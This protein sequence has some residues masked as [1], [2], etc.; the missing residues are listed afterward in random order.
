MEVN[1]FHEKWSPVRIEVQR[2]SQ[3]P[4]HL[5]KYIQ[6]IYVL[7]GSIEIEVI[8]GKYLISEGDIH[9]I[10]IEDIHGMRSYGNEAVILVLSIN[11]KYYKNT[12]PD[13]DKRIF[14]SYGSKIFRRDEARQ[15]FKNL[16]NRALLQYHKKVENE[17][18]EKIGKDIIEL[19]YGQFQY[20]N[21]NFETKKIETARATII[22]NETRERLNRIISDIYQNYNQKISIE[23][24]A[25]EEHMSKFYLSHFI[26]DYTGENYSNFVYMVRVEMSEYELLITDMSVS[27]IARNCGFSSIYYYKKHFVKWFGVT[28]EEFRRQHWHKTIIHI[29]PKFEI[30]NNVEKY[31]S[32]DNCTK[33][34]VDRELPVLVSG[35]VI[36][37]LL[38]AAINLKYMKMEYHL[39]PLIEMLGKDIIA[40]EEKYI[41]TK[42]GKK[43]S[44]AIIGRRTEKYDVR[45]INFGDNTIELRMVEIT[46]EGGHLSKTTLIPDYLGGLNLEI[47]IKK[48]S[49]LIISTD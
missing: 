26:K 32:C 13:I 2:I 11:T 8:F 38:E 43:V 46:V 10:N 16:L 20:Y 28:P 18:L 44:I 27:K 47:D 42:S 7:E 37:D 4:L 21:I 31:I 17:R 22:D 40:A 3:Y 49:I 34:T 45:F 15:L 24:L 23:K 41:I 48:G 5:H 19:L 12:F 14:I 29:D 9:I 30:V 25:E 35:S 39:H 6:I 1:I 36:R 33:I